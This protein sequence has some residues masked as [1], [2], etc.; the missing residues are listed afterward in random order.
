MINFDVIT[1]AL[2]LVDCVVLGHASLN[3]R[4][5]VAPHAVTALLQQ[6]GISPRFMGMVDDVVVVNVPKEKAGLAKLLLGQ[7][8]LN[9]TGW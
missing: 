2:R 9:V 5:D 1:N 7:S 6:N 3:V 8:G 4:G